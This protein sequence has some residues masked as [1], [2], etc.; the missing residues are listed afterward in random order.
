MM[1]KIAAS[2]ALLVLIGVAATRS[3]AIVTAHPGGQKIYRSDADGVAINLMQVLWIDNLKDG[4]KPTAHFRGARGP[5]E[6]STNNVIS[7]R[8]TI[9]TLGY[10]PQND[11]SFFNPEQVDKYEFSGTGDKFVLYL[12]FYDNDGT[13]GAK[14]VDLRG[15]K[16]HDVFKW[17]KEKSGG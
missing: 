6:L 5:V 13:G 1:K 9:S 10:Q 2:A 4:H 11:T 16:A 3:D 8:D 14:R 12:Y 15:S 7:L 17:L